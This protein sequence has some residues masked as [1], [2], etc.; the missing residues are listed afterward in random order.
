MLE[1]LAQASAAVDPGNCA[2]NYPSAR[3]HKKA[4][5]INRALHDFDRNT[6]HLGG[7]FEEIASVALI[8]PAV[9]DTWTQI[10]GLVQHRLGS[11]AILDVGWVDRGGQQ[12]AFG[13]NYHLAFAT[14]DLFATIKATRATS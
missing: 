10:V 11:H 4:F 9:C 2:L 7:P 12:I 13:V 3:K 1:I 8:G 5:L 6:K 14:F